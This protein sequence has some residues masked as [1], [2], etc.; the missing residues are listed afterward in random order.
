LIDILTIFTS[1]TQEWATSRR[2]YRLLNVAW[3][4]IP[5]TSMSSSAHTF[6]SEQLWLAHALRRF[7]LVD[8]RRHLLYCRYP[9]PKRS[10]LPHKTVAAKIQAR[11]LMH[12]WKHYY[13]VTMVIY[14]HPPCRWWHD[15]HRL[16]SRTTE[17]TE[18][19][20]RIHR[21]IQRGGFNGF[22]MA[23]RVRLLRWK[24]YL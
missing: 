20:G 5:A 7:S 22:K 8:G 16:G 11:G 19:Q 9:I 21:V 1:W 4:S 14:I 17:S 18:W 6:R 23:A 10:W 12:Y 2:R 24:I 15:L 13:A 3:C